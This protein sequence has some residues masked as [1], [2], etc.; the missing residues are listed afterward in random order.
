M[1]YAGSG[2]NVI[3][4]DN[5]RHDPSMPE[6]GVVDLFSRQD[7]SADEK[8]TRD[9]DF[10]ARLVPPLHDTM[11]KPFQIRISSGRRLSGFNE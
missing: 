2:A 7:V 9:G 1:S 10:C 11:V 6:F 5:P 8:L 4:M 3:I